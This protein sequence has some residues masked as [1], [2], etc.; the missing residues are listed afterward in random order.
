MIFIFSV[1]NKKFNFSE[2]N[3]LEKTDN[4]KSIE[5]G[6]TSFCGF[7]NY[8]QLVNETVT[9]IDIYI[10]LQIHSVE[11]SYGLGGESLRET[12]TICIMHRSL[13]AV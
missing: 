10:T 3:R 6:V 12:F 7:I 5:E 8:A 11:H 1:E 9:H 2:N 4:N 13:L